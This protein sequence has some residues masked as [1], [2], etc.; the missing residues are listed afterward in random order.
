MANFGAASRAEL[1][2]CHPL[3]VVLAETVVRHVDC[4]CWQGHRTSLEQEVD[5]ANGVSWTHNSKHEKSPSEAMDLSYWPMDWKD[6]SKEA[7][8]KHYWFAGYVL[9][10]AHQL[11]IAIRWGGDWDSDQNLAEERHKDLTHFELA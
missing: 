3:L 6:V 8:Q 2:T 5:V 11:G 9:A 4:K 10:T 7:I 1:K